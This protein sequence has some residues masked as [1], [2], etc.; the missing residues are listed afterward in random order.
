METVQRK[1]AI[2]QIY[3]K[4]VFLLDSVY[5]TAKWNY[6]FCCKGDS[7]VLGNWW[8]GW[9]SH[10]VLWLGIRGHNYVVLKFSTFLM[11]MS[12][13]LDLLGTFSSDKWNNLL[14]CQH[15]ACFLG[16]KKAV[17]EEIFF[18]LEDCKIVFRCIKVAGTQFLRLKLSSLNQAVWWRS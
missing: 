9:D 5:G 4:T 1:G 17:K 7:L 15:P 8:S 3:R 16:K 12:E 14:W 11:D 18:C 13:K 10:C 6:L 2:V